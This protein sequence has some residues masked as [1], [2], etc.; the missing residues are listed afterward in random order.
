MESWFHRRWCVI[1]VFRVIDM[2]EK[3]CLWSQSCSL[4]HMVPARYRRTQEERP[5]VFLHRIRSRY[6]QYMCQRKEVLHASLFHRLDQRLWH[7]RSASV[8]WNCIQ[9][10]GMVYTDTCEQGT[11]NNKRL[12]DIYIAPPPTPCTH[13]HMHTCTL[14][15]QPGRQKEEDLTRSSLWYKLQ[16]DL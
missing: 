11:K 2:R 15:F 10:S 1:L 12:F 8:S 13:A 6:V 4:L 14:P 5:R 7:S 16:A 9:T 3:L